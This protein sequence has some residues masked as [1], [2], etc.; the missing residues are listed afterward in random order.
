MRITRRNILKYL[1]RRQRS[2]H[3]LVEKFG[4]ERPKNEDKF[5]RLSEVLGDLVREGV[6]ERH[7]RKARPYYRIASDYRENMKKEGRRR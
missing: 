7:V 5:G 4:W 3:A 6:V 1:A 2:M